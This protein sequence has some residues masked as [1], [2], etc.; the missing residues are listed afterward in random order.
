[1]GEYKKIHGE[2]H[3]EI[4]ARYESRFKQIKVQIGQ[5]ED[6]TAEHSKEIAQN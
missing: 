3:L 1:M 4:D 6:K 2:F 5:L